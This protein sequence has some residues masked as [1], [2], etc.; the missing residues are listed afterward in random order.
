MPP[1][2]PGICNACKC[3][4][5]RGFWVVCISVACR[6]Q[7]WVDIRWG[8]WR[9]R[10]ELKRHWAEKGWFSD[11]F[12]LH[13]NSR[14]PSVLREKMSPP[15]PTTTPISLIPLP[16]LTL[17]IMSPTIASPLHQIPSPHSPT[18]PMHTNFACSCQRQRPLARQPQERVLHCVSLCGPVWGSP[19]FWG[20]KLFN[21]SLALWLACPVGRLCKQKEFYS[22]YIIENIV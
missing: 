21:N 10:C 14:V 2:S 17:P 12:K 16:H 1:I 20:P 3:R 19:L 4:K 6:R 15:L 5:S 11:W 13:M 9:R 18:L 8:K 7:L 22:T